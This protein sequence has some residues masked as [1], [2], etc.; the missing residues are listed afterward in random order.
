LTAA[1]QEEFRQ[2]RS[3]ELKDSPAAARY[4]GAAA[5]YGFSEVYFN[6]PHPVALVF[7]AHWCGGLC[8]Q[9][10][11]VAFALQGG[12]WKPLQWRSSSRIS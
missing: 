8:G 1:E 7:A 6:A 4:K 2:T 11:W 3:P 5:I 12:V 10:F 9:G